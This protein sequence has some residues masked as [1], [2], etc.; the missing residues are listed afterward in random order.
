MSL[1]AIFLISLKIKKIKLLCSMFFL[2]KISPLGNQ[3]KKKT[4]TNLTKIFWELFWFFIG[5]SN[6]N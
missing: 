2:G 3:K 4:A 6:T 1:G 5:T